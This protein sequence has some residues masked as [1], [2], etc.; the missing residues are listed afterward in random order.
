MDVDESSNAT[1]RAVRFHEYGEPVEVLRLDRIVVPGSPPGLIRIVVHGC[2]LN[3][4]DWALCRGL[5][6]GA[7]PRG[8]GLEVSGVVDAVGDVAVGDRVM[9]TADYAGAP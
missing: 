4:A 1:M 8:V 6:P 3:S 2:G 5:F 9:G 7:L